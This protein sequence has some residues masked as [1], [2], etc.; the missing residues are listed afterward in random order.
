M[1]YSAPL[2]ALFA[3]LASPR[4]LFSADNAN[5][6]LPPAAAAATPVTDDNPTLKEV[7]FKGVRL[8]DAVSYLRQTCPRFKVVVVPDP[9]CADP[10]PV[11]PDIN[12]KNVDLQQFLEVLKQTLPQL[13]IEGVEGQQGPVCLLKV[14]RFLGRNC[15]SCRFTD[16]A[17]SFPPAA[18]RKAYLND[19]LSLV[20][21]ALEAQ[22]SASNV[23]MKVHEGTGTLI[24]RGNA[25]KTEVV[26]RALKALAP[27]TAESERAKYQEQMQANRDRM[28]ERSA[29]LE[30]RLREAEAE[31]N[32]ARKRISEQTTEIE[33]LKARLAGRATKS[34]KVSGAFPFG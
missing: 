20:Q 21:A 7:S 14:A 16:L 8:N 28:G 2:F 11:L 34:H 1:R 22:G 9:Q 12:L 29:Q 17:R 30:I 5:G 27:T 26:E 10:D 33:V 25:A 31:S 4:L 18:D 24:F 13:S 6:L 19:I 23:L 3:L 32:D 15:H